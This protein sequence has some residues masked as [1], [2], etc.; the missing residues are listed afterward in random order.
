MNLLDDLRSLTGALVDE[1]NDRRALGEL[2]ETQVVDLLR[3]LEDL[4][5]AACAT[6]ADLAVRLDHTVRAREAAAGVAAAR[7]GRGVAQQVALARRESPYRGR[8]LLGFAK[9]LATDL[10]HTRTALA[11][12]RLNEHRAMII[13][14]ET[15]CL[16]SYQRSQ[17]D[18]DT[19]APADAGEDD[20]LD[21]VGTAR[22]AG[23][24]RARVA[25]T[26]PAAVVRRQRRAESERRVSVR[27]APDGMAYLSGLLSLTQAVA[28]Y[29]AL[30]RDATAIVAA[31]DP[32]HPGRPRSK[33]QVMADLLVERITGQATAD[34]VPVTVS[35]VMSDA[36]LLGAGHEPAHVPGHGPVP[37]QVARETVAR[38]TT[39]MQ[40]WVRRLYTDPAG[41]LIALSTT[42]RLATEGLADYLNA[43]DQGLCRTPWCDAPARHVDHITPWADGG[44]TDAENLQGLCEACNHA[45][46]ATGWRQQALDP[47]DEVAGRHLV[48][49]TTPTGHRHRSPAPPPPKP[50]RPADPESQPTS[51]VRPR[52]DV[53]FT[54]LVDFVH[55]A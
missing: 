10:P 24:V 6:Q 16:D 49:T 36:T 54:D 13:A 27:P 42:Q 41:K 40:A 50:A 39:A 44:T 43:R 30:D 48:E 18:H 33:Q 9:D 2:T 19:S 17:V 47:L 7:R 29:A 4:K 5:A 25:A 46:Q 53:R 32:T 35:L 23:Q 15:G 52:V 38:A 11:S 8:V 28:C 31:G 22:L 26:D 34:A 21:G 51:P 20:P 37:A 55:A 12:G 3:S 1:P 14:R 45:K